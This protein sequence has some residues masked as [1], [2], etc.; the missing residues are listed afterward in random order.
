MVIISLAFFKI[1]EPFYL[2]LYLHVYTL[3][4]TH[5]HKEKTNAMVARENRNCWFI[6]LEASSIGSGNVSAY[7][8][9]RT[10]GGVWIM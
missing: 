7:K 1:L 4:K 8:V 5:I 2:L 3:C 6:H 9:K 10:G